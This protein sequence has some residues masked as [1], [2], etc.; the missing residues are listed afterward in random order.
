MKGYISFN[1]IVSKLFHSVLAAAILISLLG[2]VVVRSEILVEAEA[3]DRNDPV[4][5]T[6]SSLIN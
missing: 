6:I 5:L 2:M 1:V 3:N 4:R